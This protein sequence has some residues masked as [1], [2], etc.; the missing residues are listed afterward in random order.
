MKFFFCQ[1]CGKRLTEND[2][3]EG[4]ARDKK[5]KGVYCTDCAVG[6]V[7]MEDLPLSEAE[8]RK[9]VSEEMRGRSATPTDQ[10][11]GVLRFY[12][13]ESCNK[14]LTETD[15][16]KGEG[17]DK[18]RRGIF[19]KA[20]GVGVTT[21]EFATLS[22][23]EAHKIVRDSRTE[24]TRRQPREPSSGGKRGRRTSSLMRAAGIAGRNE[25]D[26]NPSGKL[27]A[28]VDT[29]S[30]R[31][32]GV[33]VVAFGVL[34]ALVLALVLLGGFG[35]DSRKKVAGKSPRSDKSDGVES[36]GAVAPA[37]ATPS[38]RSP[39]EAPVQSEP[40]AKA[41]AQDASAQPSSS[42]KSPASENGASPQQPAPSGEDSG[43]GGGE[44]AAQPKTGA[45]A[46]PPNAPLA[47][48][49]QRENVEPKASKKPVAAAKPEQPDKQ[50]QLIKAQ[51]AYALFAERFLQ[52]LREGDAAKAEAKWQ[53]AQSDPVLAPLK[54]QVTRHRMA[55]DWLKKGEQL[56]RKGAER[57]KE[58]DDFEIHTGSPR[59]MRVGRKH[60]FQVK[61]V[62]QETIFVG[63]AQMDMPVAFKRIAAP[64]RTALTAL[65]LSHDGDGM[66]HRAFLR[67]IALAPDGKARSAR[68]LIEKARKAGVP[69]PTLSYLE[70]LC[71]LT[72][73]GAREIAAEKNWESIQQYVA[74][75]Q[76]KA[77]L[78]GLDSLSEKYAGTRWVKSNAEKVN[79]L[80]AK[81]KGQV[82]LAEGHYYDFDTTT[83]FARFVEDFEV[84]EKGR[85]EA[86][87]A[88]V[89]VQ[90]HEGKQ[91]KITF[92]TKPASQSSPGAD[93]IRWTHKHFKWKGD[94]EVRVTLTWVGATR[95][96]IRR[97]VTIPFIQEEDLTGG[98]YVH[99]FTSYCYGG[100]C[101]KNKRSR[102]D[103]QSNV[104][105][106]TDGF[107]DFGKPLKLK[108]VK[109]GNRVDC[110]L[111]GRSI[112]GGEIPSEMLK[113]MQSQPFQLAL[114]TLGVKQVATIDDLYIGPIRPAPPQ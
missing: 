113:R 12:F 114:T 46:R 57:L 52:T 19:C 101:G 87:R 40:Q 17:K 5:L 29:A 34:A 70:E 56:L 65:A 102:V 100:L 111:N 77:A 67:T 80:R 64:T 68:P 21:V 13:C 18:Q 37:T 109:K 16:A 39:K 33:A 84:S 53:K 103:H 27:P 83:S 10:E 50:D 23:A 63:N 25:T 99:L 81:A 15:I 28:P 75:R 3:A 90:E 24:T 35:S 74:K 55:L 106:K 2:I 112:Y 66:A 58:V 93:P 82:A 69:A 8:A 44:E 7:T 42:P 1:T 11:S 43:A 32:V 20:C 4:N 31:W 59:P 47:E 14:R 108:W 105:R 36:S 71:V 54:D 51:S 89:G 97:M 60:P 92:V 107:S 26:P 86:N 79:A 110:W 94:W 22:N 49:A 9:L 6:V 104:F 62:T 30:P 38:E 41:V 98:C 45:P 48:T 95:Q 73:K 85:W 96:T 91:L 88:I 76:W 72:E 61:R 78:D